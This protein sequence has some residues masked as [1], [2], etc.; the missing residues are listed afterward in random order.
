L[1]LPSSGNPGVD[2]RRPG[3]HHDVVNLVR[4]PGESCP[5]RVRPVV[6]P[7]GVVQGDRGVVQLSLQVPDRFALLPVTVEVPGEDAGGGAGVQ[8][9][10]PR[11]AAAVVTDPR[12]LVQLL[13]LL[14]LPLLSRADQFYPAP[15]DQSEGT[16]T[17][18]WSEFTLWRDE[19][20]DTLNLSLYSAPGLQWAATSFIQPQV[21]LHDRFLYDRTTSQ[22]TVSRF[23]EDLKTRYGGVDSLLLWQGYPNIGLDD[24]N[25]F[26]M[27]ASL[28]G[29][30]DGLKDLVSQLQA[31]G[32][33]VL[34]P[35][36]PWDQNTNPAGQDH[37]AALVDQVNKLP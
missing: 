13:V 5:V 36:L 14:L 26:E 3:V 1:V 25:Q 6:G 23:L 31:A 16:F 35:Y 7:E 37:V 29:G 2:H 17:E 19:T 8:A 28:P 22:W 15:T 10:L 20:R 27:T 30:L 32:V 24:K 9:V 33:R 11:E 18:W 21:M 4:V 12:A 34:L